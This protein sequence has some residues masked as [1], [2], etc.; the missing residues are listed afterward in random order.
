MRTNTPPTSRRRSGTGVSPARGAGLSG[1]AHA[2]LPSMKSNEVSIEHQYEL[3][4]REPTKFRDIFEQ[5]FDHL[6]TRR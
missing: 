6:G 4:R 1:H 2:G 3:Y 5:V